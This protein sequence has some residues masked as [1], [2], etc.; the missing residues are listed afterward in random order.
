ML[1]KIKKI[2]RT[3]GSEASKNPLWKSFI[4]WNNL[5]IHAYMY[6]FWK[7]I[8]KNYQ[9]SKGRWIPLT[10]EFHLTKPSQ[11]L[12]QTLAQTL[13]NGGRGSQQVALSSWH[14][15]G[16]KCFYTKK[17]FYNKCSALVQCSAEFVA[18]LS[19]WDDGSSKQGEPISA[20]PADPANGTQTSNASV[21]DEVGP[22]VPGGGG[23]LSG[24]FACFG[25][26]SDQKGVSKGPNAAFSEEAAIDMTSN[27]AINSDLVKKVLVCC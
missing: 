19:F 2:L 23:C 5:S 17:C 4:W 25:F 20:N 22:S 10:K 8:K 7:K 15:S 18:L 14:I 24:V 11:T 1:K 12:A 26:S 21:S 9:V 16:Y 27:E 3:Q 13:S 6:M